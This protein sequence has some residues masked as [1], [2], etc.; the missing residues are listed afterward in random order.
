MTT[1]SETETGN[2]NPGAVLVIVLVSYLMIVLDTSIVITG[3]PKIRDGL[4]FTPSALSWVQNAYMLSFGGL[5]LLGARAGDIAGRRRMF[6]WG[7]GLFTLSSMAIGLAQTPAA[8]VAGRAVQGIGA[9]VLAPST[10]ALLSVHFAEGAERTRALAYYAAVAGGGASLGLL[11]GGLLAGE[12]SWR[13]GFFMNVPIG[14]GLMIVARLIL[15][16]TDRQTGRFDLAGALSST[17]GMTALVFGIERSAADGFYDETVLASLG[18]SILLL[19]FFVINERKA[20]QPILPL[21]LF[22]SRQRSA[23]YLAR[24]LFIGAMLGFF[25][26]TTQFLQDVFGFTPTQAGMAFLPL[27]IPSFLAS[28]FVPRLTAR[29]GNGGLMALALAFG[30]A[31]LFWLGQA[32]AHSSFIAGFALPMILIG[33]GNGAA[34][35][36]LTVA[37]VSGVRSEDTGAA[38]G[39]V[40]VFHQLGGA[41]GLAVLLVVF[42]LVSPQAVESSD[43]LARGL[44]FTFTAGGTFLA[45]ALAIALAFLVRNPLAGR[46][47]EEVPALS[48][49]IERS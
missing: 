38:S 39:L 48:R 47:V 34:L 31:G 23:A 26:F 35:G 13:V 19:L 4:G 20:E 25:F 1:P 29:L 30:S 42:S 11:V 10:L 2:V 41:L 32:T 6:I 36:P 5:L 43:E 33:L 28:L 49:V 27:T 12:L 8:L 24:M 44:A 22:N 17:L 21:R 18:A 7:L 3:L 15:D 46:G 16:E 37:S 40:N 45:T 9:A 14:I